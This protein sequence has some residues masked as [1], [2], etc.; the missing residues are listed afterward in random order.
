MT[1]IESNIENSA[2]TAVKRN[3]QF[4]DTSG[5]KKKNRNRKA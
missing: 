5:H 1:L 3:K 4:N 2:E